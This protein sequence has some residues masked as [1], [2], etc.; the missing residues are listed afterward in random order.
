MKRLIRSLCA[1]LA[2]ALPSAA[3]AQD[4]PSKPIRAIGG[5]APGGLSDVF[6]RTLGEEL[7]KRWGQPVVVEN[8]PGGA[9]NIGA[10]ACAE[11]P[12]DGYTICILPNDPMTYNP[13]LFKSLPFDPD[14]SF[15]P[16]TNLFFLAQVLAVNSSLNVKTLDGLAA[17]SKANPNKLSYSSP[18]LALVFFLESFKRETG[19]DMVRVRS[20]AAATR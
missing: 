2:V 9:F 8:R 14:K 6:I 15:E 5:S 19:A 10:R 7:H 13:H 12:P 16:I 11:A 1:A 18:S 17:Y 20:R 4:Y 3:V